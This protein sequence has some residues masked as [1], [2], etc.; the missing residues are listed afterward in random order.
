[1]AAERFLN[2]T[3]LIISHDVRHVKLSGLME[4][5]TRRKDG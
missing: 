5:L 2:T 3:R 1:M 4:T